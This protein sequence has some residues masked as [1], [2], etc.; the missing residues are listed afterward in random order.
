MLRLSSPCAGAAVRCVLLPPERQ[1]AWVTYAFGA[2]GAARAG[3]TRRVCPM[4]LNDGAPRPVGA[5]YPRPG[6]SVRIIL[7]TPANFQANSNGH[8]PTGHDFT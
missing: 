1:V 8:A 6:M 7:N 3:E 4:H 2:V 5:R